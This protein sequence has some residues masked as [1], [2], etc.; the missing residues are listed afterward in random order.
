MDTDLK[1]IADFTLVKWSKYS[2]TIGDVVLIMLLVV[3]LVTFLRLLR[4][5]LTRLEKRGRIDK[6]RSNSVYQIIKYIVLVVAIVS[7]L[8]AIGIQ[9]SILLAGSAALLVGL[10]LGLQDTF[11][12]IVSGLILLIE[13]NLQV[14]DIIEV[15]SMI[16]R[17]NEIKL[18]TSEI[19]TRDGVNII[20]PNHKFVTDNVINWS[21]NKKPSRY[22][23]SVGVAYKSDVVQVQQ[24]LYSCVKELSGT[25]LDVEEYKPIV[26]LS[27]FGESSIDFD[28]LFWSYN[29]FKSEGMCSDLRFI[30]AK[31]FAENKI[32]IP[33]PQRDLH[34]IGK[35][36]KEEEGG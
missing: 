14:G 8:Q 36:L 30:I 2:I 10:G 24:I 27:D 18:R 11:N 21:H 16:G 35:Q 17:V 22:R 3:F 33:F 7:T 28:I 25:V 4:Y 12:D 31:K 6:G 9:I 32:E 13:G 5:F 1:E 29:Y 26:R 20:V 23:V 19:V 15:D 34:I